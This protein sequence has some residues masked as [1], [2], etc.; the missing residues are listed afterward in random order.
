MSPSRR[1]LVLA[2]G[3]AVAL[4]AALLLGP[5][6][7]KPDQVWH[8]LLN[9]S[10]ADT[11]ARIVWDARLPRVFLAFVVGAA[12]SVAGAVMQ[13]FF[14]NPLAESSIIGVSAGAYLGATIAIVTGLS[15]IGPWVSLPASA[16]IGALAAVMV[17]YTL[18]RRGGTTPVPTLLL[19]GIAIGSL[20]SA[21]AS[22][23]MIR[24]QRGDMDLVVFWMLG[25]LA[26]RGW[27]EVAIITPYVA[28]ATVLAVVFA[29][30]LDVLSLGDEQAAYLGLP[31]RSVRIGFIVLA[32]LLAAAEV[33]VTGIIGF[34][35][36]VVPHIC[37]LL[38]GARHRV[39]I[40]TAA[41]VGMIV[42]AWADVVANVSGEIPV[43]IVTA[44]LGSPFFLWLL[45]QR[46][47][48]RT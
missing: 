36:L 9:P 7:L 26:N 24:A 40:P 12:L 43:G 14:Q 13:G 28:V 48:H 17:V 20:C 23:I 45:R 32:A 6:G 31:V 27:T 10:S 42:L 21:I 34:V 44:A 4:A 18:A 35:G 15:R 5:S 38:F 30:Y 2:L 39:L 46:E 19:T 47:L 37:R 29:R 16:F 41:V 1:L 8:A 25:S 11:A 33:S 3:L 22:L